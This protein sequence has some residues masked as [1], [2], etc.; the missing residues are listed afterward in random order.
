MYEGHLYWG[1]FGF[2]AAL[3]MPAFAVVFALAWWAVF[4][5]KRS[6]RL[7]GTGAS[8]ITTGVALSPI[9]FPPHSVMSFSYSML[10]LGIAGLVA[11]G[12]KFEFVVLAKA[13]DASIRL[14]G[15]GTNSLLNK[16]SQIVFLAI[17]AYTYHEWS[18]WVR[19]RD[20]PVLDASWKGFIALAIIGLV[21]A[22]LHEL[23]HAVVG[24]ALGMKLRSFSVGPFQWQIRDGKWEFEFS[25]GQILIVGGRTGA[26]PPRADFP[27]WAQLCMSSGGAAANVV[28]GILAVVAV[29]GTSTTPLGSLL[30]LFGSW[31]LVT[32]AMNLV[33][34]RA[35][36]NYSDGAQIYQLLSNGPWTDYYRAVAAAG[37]SLVTGVRPKDYDINVIRRA[38]LTINA[39][40]Q[41][42]LLRL[43]A[44][45]YFLDQG[46]INEAAESLREAGL[47]YNESPS[48]VPVELLPAFVFGSGY[49]C[50]D[51]YATRAWWTH[52]EA[53][54][55]TRFNVDYWLAAG[56]LHWIEG[57]L[58]EA[59]AAW[60]K[61]NTQAQ[62]LPRSGA[63]DFARHCCSLL[64][65]VLDE[66]PMPSS[67]KV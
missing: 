24:F 57:N 61:A 36:Y 4:K 2:G 58:D 18:Q 49:L 53:T 31:S 46:R 41:G 62:Q 3:M 11:F 33:P 30:A 21:I 25:P 66:S 43:F 67:A 17:A 38:G 15:D 10:A 35:G 23:G 5:R 47:I 29:P 27:R 14:P 54:N 1:L 63:Y 52:W 20:L 12:P 56:A 26:V 32:G 7:W 64:R 44:Y 16:S 22:L 50:R 6:A 48:H 55:P 19:A 51:P 8:L 42:L 40:F 45:N 9:V 65:R 37:S 13:K 59:D 28:T 34:F 39:G 60:E